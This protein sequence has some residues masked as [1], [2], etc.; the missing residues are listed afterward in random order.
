VLFAQD[1]RYGAGIPVPFFGRPAHT[2]T[3]FAALAWRT[4]APLMGVCQWRDGGRH[5]CRVERLE[6]PVPVARAEAVQTLTERTQ[7]W[8]EERI[9]AHPHQWLWL[10]DRWR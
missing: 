3:G 5:L 10:H 8:I 4:R 2:A 7:V 1:Q 9:R 6:W